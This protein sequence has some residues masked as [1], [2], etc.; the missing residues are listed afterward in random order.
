VKVV[1]TGAAGFLGSRVAERLRRAGHEVVAVDRGR[2][3]S[4]DGAPAE[5]IVRL[6]LAHAQLVDVFAGADA[7]VHLAGTFPVDAVSLDGAAADLDLAVRVLEEAAAAGAR[8]ALILSTAMVYGAW[9]TNPVPIT[10]DAPVRPNPGFAF[11]VRSAELERRALDWRAAHPKV[12]LAVLRPTVIVADNQ[13][14]RVARLLRQVGAIRTDEDPPAQYLHIDDLV[15]AV[16]VATTAEVDGVLNVAADGW[17]HPEMLHALAWNRPR[18]RVSRWVLNA[19]AELRWRSG[20][21]G[22]PPGIVPY[23]VYPWV[24]ANDRLRALGWHPSNTNEEAFV[25]AHEAGPLGMLNA[26]RRQ[27]LAL[28]ATGGV[29]AS[30]AGT[31]TWLVARRRRR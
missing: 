17:I 29:L 31:I 3:A 21:A 10:E 20:L 9:P 27:Q 14:S 15:E 1:V 24:V 8:H 4:A 25:A 13:P 18:P 7:V 11:A 6:D 26:R 30:V 19:I 23:T 5:P 16:V 12:G 28:G 22:A 2:P